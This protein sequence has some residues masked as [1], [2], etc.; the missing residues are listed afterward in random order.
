MLLLHSRLYYAHAVL[1]K[2]IVPRSEGGLVSLL[3]YTP[4]GSPLN[5]D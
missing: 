2:V 5:Y 1:R 4:F 3:N